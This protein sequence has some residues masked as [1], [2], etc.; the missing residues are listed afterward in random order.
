MDMPPSKKT[1]FNP[2]LDRLITEHEAAAFIGYTTRALQNWRVRGGGPRFVRISG[3]SVR[4]RHRDLIS[5]VEQNLRS[6]T[7]D[8]ARP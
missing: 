5:W 8:E 4:Y 6:S 3:R 1:G 7:S 2:D